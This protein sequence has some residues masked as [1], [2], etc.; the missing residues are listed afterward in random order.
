[1]EEEKKRIIINE[2]YWGI[3]IEKR[4]VSDGGDIILSALI[5]I[6]LRVFV[7]TSH[8]DGETWQLTPGQLF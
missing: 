3:P 2:E 1:M 6:K 8:D 4:F 7:V 5:E